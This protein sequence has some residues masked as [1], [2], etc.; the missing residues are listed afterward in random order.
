MK[1]RELLKPD[2]RKVI[3]FIL[4]LIP[5]SLMFFISNQGEE[6]LVDKCM[7]YT[8]PLSCP[9]WQGCM[10]EHYFM[11]SI[12]LMAFFITPLI[13]LYI[14]SCLIVWIYDKRKKKT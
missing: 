8:I 3:I 12:L 10:E 14:F 13:I 2:W 5:F 9:S 1:W 4:F 6:N 11:C 7:Y